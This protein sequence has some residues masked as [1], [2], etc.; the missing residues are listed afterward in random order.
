VQTTVR[1]LLF[2]FAVS[3]GVLLQGIASAQTPIPGYN[4]RRDN[5]E[6]RIDQGV[7]SG[8]LTKKE[9]AKLR[10]AQDALD[11]KKK[12][13]EADGRLTMREKMTLRR[14][15]DALSAKIFKKKHDN[16]DR[17]DAVRPKLK[18]KKEP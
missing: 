9:A 8:E 3:G 16:D 18:G 2:A 7:K 12:K 15:Q 1:T 6:A 13:F 4:T 14:E 11:D 17:D 10:D 5:Q